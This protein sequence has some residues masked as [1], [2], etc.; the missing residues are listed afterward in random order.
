LEFFG[1]LV[2][3]KKAPKFDT[4]GNFVE[5]FKTLHENVQEL[6]KKKS[7]GGTKVWCIQLKILIINT[8]QL[9]KYKRWLPVMVCLLTLISIKKVVA[10]Y[11][12]VKF[13]D[14][15]EFIKPNINDFVEKWIPCNLLWT[16]RILGF[17]YA[18]RLRGNEEY[19]LEKF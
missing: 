5:K 6:I 4:W 13:H 1:L 19:C 7:H 18:M 3:T 17:E 9:T 11:Q 12:I 8:A 10:T 16:P 15:R 14:R 2:Y